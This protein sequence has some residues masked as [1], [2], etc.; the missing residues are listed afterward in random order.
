M[1]LQSHQ[2]T[3]SQQALFILDS[4]KKLCGCTHTCG[5]SGKM[6]LRKRAYIVLGLLSILILYGCDK[7]DT[8]TN[9]NASNQNLFLYEEYKSGFANE[10]TDVNIVLQDFEKEVKQLKQIKD[11][12]MNF[13]QCVFEEMPNIEKVEV[14]RFAEDD[15]TSEE[16]WTIIEKWLTDIGKIK[17]IDM[18]TEVRDA[19][20]V[21]PMESDKEYPYDYP[22]V[23]DNF[24]TLSSGRGFFLNTSECY[25]QLGEYGIYSMS[26]GTLT[27]YLGS[28]TLAAID[29][30][31]GNQENVIATY[32][33]GEIE[34]VNIELIDGSYSASD[35]LKLVKHYF[36]KGTPFSVAEGVSVDI[37][38]IEVFSLNDKQGCTFLLRRRY[39]NIPFAYCR[40]G[41]RSYYESNY[42]VQEDMKS[43]YIINQEGVCAFT[44]YSESEPFEVVG[45]GEEKI[46]SIKQAVA[47]L[48]ENLANELKL[49]VQKAELVYCPILFDSGE[50]V[51]IVCWMFDGINSLNGQKMR[52]YVDVLSG[53]IHYY[54]YE[55]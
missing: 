47:H 34:K 28:D 33:G 53:D 35:A 38:E 15:L 50:K 7:K 32:S 2:V 45:Q 20:G 46:L 26:D 16:G 39:N 49:N 21:L 29:A 11:E 52:L 25:V 5:R 18:K 10:R 4:A 3:A 51:G 31:G 30:L 54:S 40:E 6:S 23:F 12:K 42:I 9:T 22:N 27:K 43:A 14:I 48:N 8:T 37:P 55:E 41:N 19:S 17:D 44:G 24:E 13:Q 36:E 1:L